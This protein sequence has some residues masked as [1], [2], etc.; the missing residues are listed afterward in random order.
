[1]CCKQCLLVLRERAEYIN[2]KVDYCHACTL[3]VRDVC[4][5]NSNDIFFLYFTTDLCTVKAGEGYVFSGTSRL[6]FEFFFFFFL[7]QVGRFDSF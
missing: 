6:G 4:V 3:Y 2:F 7:K 5:T 1:M